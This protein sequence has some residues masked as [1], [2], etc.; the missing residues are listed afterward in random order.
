MTR[1]KKNEGAQP[2]LLTFIVPINGRPREYPINIFRTAFPFLYGRSLL[3]QVSKGLR[4]AKISASV[5][6]KSKV[7]CFLMCFNDSFRLFSAWLIDYKRVAA[8]PTMGLAGRQ[9]IVMGMWIYNSVLHATSIS[10][11]LTYVIQN[12][13]HYW[14]RFKRNSIQMVA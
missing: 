8:I 7:S 6:K 4:E 10:F 9:W 13:K 5:L 14:R 2:G 12:V 3:V 1:R 11:S